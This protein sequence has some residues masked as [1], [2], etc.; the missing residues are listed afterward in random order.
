[1]SAFEASHGELYLVPLR[2]EKNKVRGEMFPGPLIFSITDMG[3]WLPADDE[4]QQ[5]PAGYT[6]LREVKSF[7]G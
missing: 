5:P 1:M 4:E 6:N 3:R 2:R 7:N